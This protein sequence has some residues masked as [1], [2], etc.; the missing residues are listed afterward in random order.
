M[1]DA[2]SF[3]ITERSCVNL[4]ICKQEQLGHTKK[5]EKEKK[6][7]KLRYAFTAKM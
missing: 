4:H 7:K 1:I 2:T 3:L 6:T 5:K